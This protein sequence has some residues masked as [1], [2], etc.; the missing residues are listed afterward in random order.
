[1][2]CPQTLP[3]KHVLGQACLPLFQHFANAHYRNKTSLKCC[4]KF[5]IHRVVGFAE[6]LAPLRV[7]DDHVRAANGEQ[8]AGRNLTGE[9]ALFFPIHVL[10]A[11]GDVRSSRSLHR[12]WNVDKRRTHGN[13]VPIVLLNV[14]QE[15]AKEIASLIGRLVHLPIC[16]HQFFAH[17]EA[18]SNLND[19]GDCSL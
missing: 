2:K 9:S 6:I 3:P 8:H 19:K 13:F 5:Q 16:S 15:V 4:F 14:R 18:F 17:Y 1:M 7:P 11:D 10:G 12:R